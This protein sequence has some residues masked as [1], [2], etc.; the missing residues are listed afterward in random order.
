MKKTASAIVGIGEVLRGA[1]LT[2]RSSMP[3]IRLP[4]SSMPVSGR[5]TST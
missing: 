3:R 1:I 2:E 4:P 5:R